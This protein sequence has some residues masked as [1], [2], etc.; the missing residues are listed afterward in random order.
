VTPPVDLTPYL[1]ALE[2]RGLF[3]PDFVTFGD[4]E[5]NSESRKNIY[6]I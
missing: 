2:A 6:Y 3:P 4:R 1:P 5:K